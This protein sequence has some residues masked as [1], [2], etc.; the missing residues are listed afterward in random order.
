MG[1]L[2]FVDPVDLEH[3]DE[4]F[5]YPFCLA[6]GLEVVGVDLQR[7]FAPDE[8]DVDPMGIFG[9]FHYYAGGG[10]S[11]P[12]GR[13]QRGGGDRR[14]EDQRAGNSDNGPHR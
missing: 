13:R 1:D 9:Q 12:S 3:G 10:M 14:S 11:S 8:G 5:N 4:L 6:G 2:P 7:D